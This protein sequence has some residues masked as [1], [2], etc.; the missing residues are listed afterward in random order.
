MEPKLHTLGNGLRVILQDTGDPDAGIVIAVRSGNRFET[1]DTFEYSHL[2]EHHLFDT[3]GSKK[4]PTSLDHAR[5]EDRC[6]K[7]TNAT[8]DEDIVMCYGA[9]YRRW[10]PDMLGLFAEGFHVPV[11]PEKLRRGLHQVTI[12]NDDFWTDEELL[13]QRSRELLF[14][15]HPLSYPLVGSEDNV[16]TATCFK[17]LNL[18]RKIVRARNIVIAIIGGIHPEK[19]LRLVKRHFGHLP[20]GRPLAITRYRRRVVGPQIAMLPG[21]SRKVWLALGW[22]TF[23]A[24]D[25]DRIALSIGNNI[26]CGRESSALYVNLRDAGYVYDIGSDVKHFEDTGFLRLLTSTR[27][28]RLHAVLR[29]IRETVD[30]LRCRLVPMDEFNFTT[31]YLADR[32]RVKFKENLHVAKFYAAQLTRSGRFV[33]LRQYLTQL[34]D[35]TRSD[36]RRV[37]RRVCRPETLTLVLQGNVVPEDVPLARESLDLDHL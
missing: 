35:V 24:A 29:M 32:A 5:F 7:E 25:P 10:L 16:H 9:V 14:G 12:E 21:K 28:T 22:P 34:R 23:G 37:M 11:T 26:L 27:R 18:R 13:K 4:F 20:A 19:T 31:T 1:E 6:T 17:L 2:L 3:H 33:P 8:T 36:V 30:G 15:K